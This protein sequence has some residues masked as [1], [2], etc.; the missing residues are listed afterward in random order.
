MG[1]FANPIQRK[2][3]ISFFN[4]M[5]SCTDP[6]VFVGG[7]KEKEKEKKYLPHQAMLHSSMIACVQMEEQL[8]VDAEKG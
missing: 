6:C 4:V 2:E 1:L 3:Q 7:G 8:G 5:M